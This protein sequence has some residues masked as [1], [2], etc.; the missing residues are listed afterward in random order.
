MLPQE[1]LAGVKALFFFFLITKRKTHLD[2]FSV[3][4]TIKINFFSYHHQKTFA[5]TL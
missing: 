4:Q 3:L 2:Y 1:M 5:K